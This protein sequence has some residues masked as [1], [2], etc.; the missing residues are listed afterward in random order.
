MKK[1]FLML[2]LVLCAGLHAQSR[3]E[4]SLYGGAG[5]A[6]LLY[7]DV[8]TDKFNKFKGRTDFGALGGLGYTFFFNEY[9]GLGLGA[10][11]ALYN[12]EPEFGDPIE[13]AKL[14]L[15]AVQIPLML[16]V[17]VGGWH[18]FFLAAGGKLG[19]PIDASSKSKKDGYKDWPEK[20][21]LE[22]TDA[23]I[24][25]EMGAKW[26]FKEGIYLYSGF[27]LDYGV[28]SML[29]SGYRNATKENPDMT[30][31][32]AG[33]KLRLALGGGS[34]LDPP[35]LEFVTGQDSI[36]AGQSAVL[37]WIASNAD[38]V[39]ID[40]VGA[41][42]AQG[43]AEVSPSQTERYTITAKGRGGV[44]TKSVLVAVKPLPIPSVAFS[45]SPKTILKGQAATLTWMVSDADQINMV[46]VGLMP[47]KGTMEVKPS[48]TTKYILTAKGKGGEKTEFVEVVVE[49]PPGP[50]VIFNATSPI[51]Q[52]G[53]SATLNWITTD[54]ES[55]SIEGIGP[56][57]DKGTRT[58]KPTQTTKYVLTAKG[59]DEVKTE[60]MVEIIVEEPPPIEE[61]VNLKGVNFLPGKSVLSLDAKRVLDGVVEQLLAY[62]NVRIEIQGHTD[63]LG[64]AVTNQKLSE[65]RAKAV[66]AYL[67]SKGIKLNRMKAVG[68]G[69]NQP[70]ADNSTEEGRE[71]NRRIE[72]IR[73]DK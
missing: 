55:V 1:T 54:A 3:H 50:S 47:D 36:S 57:P 49:I 43:S 11:Y 53:Q 45:I 52:K 48:E 72:M 4:F 35:V 9:C 62:P 27:Y 17:Q 73:V 23:I 29:K 60:M 67:A 59:K 61:K 71:L 6:T 7:D 51:I 64:K 13:R 31:L 25:A 32:A 28:N 33:F 65:A 42:P 46:G 26:K 24:S 66:V 38:T 39:Y 15:M 14:Q 19:L 37:K 56:V 12:S 44:E 69:P 68:Y 41:V 22:V 8:A 40:G 58:V 30:P 5:W 34:V 2:L 16:Q 18:K 10:E 63:N 70:I 21:K 20:P